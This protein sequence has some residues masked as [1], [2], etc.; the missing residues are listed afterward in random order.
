[1]NAPNIAPILLEKLASD[2]GGALGD[3]LPPDA[4]FVLLVFRPGDPVQVQQGVAGIAY[5]T[6]AEAPEALLV[7][8]GF[9]AMVDD[10]AAKAAKQ[11]A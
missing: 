8:R 7:V 9:L 10:A 4:N 11:G 5:I 3:L 6:S 2:F 1:M